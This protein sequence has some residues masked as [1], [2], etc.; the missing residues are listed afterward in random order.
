[1]SDEERLS[2][3]E[4]RK[5]DQTNI[6]EELARRTEFRTAALGAL[7]GAEVASDE[8][9]SVE[10]QKAIA[11]SILELARVTGKSSPKK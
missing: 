3:I 2:Y 6:F 11:Y 1:M 5:Q 8:A 4:K 10:A 9:A 7:A